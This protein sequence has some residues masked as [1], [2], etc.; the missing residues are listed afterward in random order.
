MPGLAAVVEAEGEHETSLASI[1][2]CLTRV[3]EVELAGL[4]GDWVVVEAVVITGAKEVA[5]AIGLVR[6]SGGTGDRL[7]FT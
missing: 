1:A 5:E 3:H 4:R 2:D 7:C 6:A